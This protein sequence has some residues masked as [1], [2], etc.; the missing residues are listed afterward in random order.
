MSSISIG[1]STDEVVNSVNFG[2]IVVDH[3][4]QILLWNDWM[5][6]HSRM[7]RQQ[8]L[9]Q[10]IISLFGEQLTPGFLRAL[11]NAI[12]YGLPAMLSSA[13]HRSPLPLFLEQDQGATPVRMHQ[14]IIMT[15][16]QGKDGAAPTCLIQISDSST[17]VKREKM[18]MSHSDALKRAAITDSLTGIYNRRFFDESYTLALRNAKRN[19]SSLSLFMI[20]VDY[21][22]PYNDHYGH[23]QGDK[24]LQMVANAL[25]AQMR[26]PTDICA[27]YGGEE[28][29]ML[30]PGITDAQAQ[31]FA[32]RLCASVADLNIAHEKSAAA[33]HL[34][35]SVGVHTMTPE[36]GSEGKSLLRG[37]DEALY[38]AKHDGRNQVAVKR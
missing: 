12:G 18:L 20:D 30:I 15:P 1:F 37:A 29:V 2:L 34:S 5:S 14:S 22:K 35:I 24:A 31:G 23:I 28:F 36:Q 25:R 9:Q 3:D 21:F 27:R 6:R 32:E 33:S 4:L 19:R 16:L 10:N 17:S 7:S 11:N 26:R 8:A 13:L 38:R